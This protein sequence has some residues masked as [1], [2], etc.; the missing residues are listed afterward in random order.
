MSG[1]HVEVFL[2]KSFSHFYWPTLFGPSPL[3]HVNR[4]WSVTL[5]SCICSPSFLTTERKTGLTDRC[6]ECISHILCMFIQ[7]VILR[8]V[9]GNGS[10]L[11]YTVHPTRGRQVTHT[12]DTVT[13]TT[14]SPV[15]QT[16]E[17]GESRVQC[18]TTGNPTKSDRKR[19]KIL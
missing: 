15:K 19:R 2:A 9:T 4:L 5:V 14:R 8:F 7:V 12:S 1:A 11:T 18:W 17:T 3:P 13:T 6:G 16:N 10:V